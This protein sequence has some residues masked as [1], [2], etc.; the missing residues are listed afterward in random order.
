MVPETLDAL[1]AADKPLRI[2]VSPA[3]QQAALKSLIGQCV[4]V[5]L[6]PRRFS[7]KRRR[8]LANQLMRAI[9]PPWDVH[10]ADIDNGP[11][12]KPSIWLEDEA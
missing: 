8:K 9:A 3:G 6:N 1:P 10:E 11:E 5:L 12:L 2:V 7:T 4:P